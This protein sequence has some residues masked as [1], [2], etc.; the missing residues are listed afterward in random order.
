MAIKGRK[1]EIC[2]RGEQSPHYS[3]AQN[4][5]VEPVISKLLELLLMLAQR[6]HT[7]AVC[8]LLYL[9]LIPPLPSLFCLFHNSLHNM[10][11]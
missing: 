2:F 6:L 7:P 1:A 4:V 8:K 3:R 10:V 9:S 11:L 5:S